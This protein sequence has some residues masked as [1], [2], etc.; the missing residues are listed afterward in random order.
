M[1]AIPSLLWVVITIAA[2]IWLVVTFLIIRFLCSVPTQLWRIANALEDLSDAY[3]E[4]N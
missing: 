1:E 4:N 3:D 2:I